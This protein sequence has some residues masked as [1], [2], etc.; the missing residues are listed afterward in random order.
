MNI[1]QLLIS[2]VLL[3]LA[4]C[5]ADSQPEQS[6]KSAGKASA[7]GVYTPVEKK[8]HEGVDSTLLDITI[9]STVSNQRVDYDAMTVYFNPQKHIPNCVVYELSATEVSQADAPEVQKRSEYKFEADPNVRGCPDWWEYKRSVYDRGHM[10]PAM[11]MRWAEEPMRQC[12]LMT[13]I[14]PQDH[15]LNGGEWRK[16]EEAIHRWAKT[17]KQLIVITG[18]ILS[19]KMETIGGE[20]NAVAVPERF[21]KIVY[22][23]TS[24]R[25]I[26]FVF[27]NENTTASWR[28]FAVTVD[29]VERMTGYDFLPAL[30]DD[31]E[32]TAEAKQ[33]IKQW[34]SV[35]DRELRNDYY[36]N[37]RSNTRNHR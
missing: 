4:G 23:T 31:V 15:D 14:C 32:N 10:A 22:S 18:P 17:E 21:F 13:N 11:D 29:E 3:S 8:W 20:R 5:I 30:P 34:P 36:Y 19:P 35:K 24:K 16:L 33:N 25:A 7:S 12:F 26:A 37:D 27:K 9:P 1:K 2:V 28:S 6:G